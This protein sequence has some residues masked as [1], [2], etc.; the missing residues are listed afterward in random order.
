MSNGIFQVRLVNLGSLG[1]LCGYG[2]GK[3]HEEAVDNALRKARETDP[4]AYYDEKIDQVHFRY[5]VCL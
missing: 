2:E 1:T 4:G 5:S 3:T